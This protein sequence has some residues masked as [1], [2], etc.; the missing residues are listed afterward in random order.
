MV[1][2]VKPKTSFAVLTSH[3]AGCEPVLSKV[4]LGACFECDRRDEEK[5]FWEKYGGSVEIKCRDTFKVV[6]A[7]VGIENPA[8][9]PHKKKN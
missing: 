8:D 2:K 3:V 1:K 9:C 7:Q 4:Q 5:G 6:S